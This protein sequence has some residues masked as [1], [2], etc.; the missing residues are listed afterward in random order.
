MILETRDSFK[1]TKTSASCQ[2][3][4]NN[5]SA[6]TWNKQ[7]KKKYKK[8][9]C[10]RTFLFTPPLAPMSHINKLNNVTHHRARPFSSSLLSANAGPVSTPIHPLPVRSVCVGRHVWRLHRLRTRPVCF[11]HSHHSL[12]PLFIC[13]N[14][15]EAAEQ[16][17]A[18][19]SGKAPFAF[20][21]AFLPSVFLNSSLSLLLFNMTNHSPP[22]PF[23][24]NHTK[25]S[26]FTAPILISL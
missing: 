9:T 20:S 5:K 8:R 11:T 15:W 19:Q 16:S 4:P 14:V 3:N 22:P 13:L 23:F 10:A 18:E 17:R 24:F 12:F 6:V 1:A 2:K 21:S 7:K 25:S 26:H